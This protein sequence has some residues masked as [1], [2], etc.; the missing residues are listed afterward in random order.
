M[1]RLRARLE[2][3][4][5]SETAPKL[6]WVDN[7]TAVHI[8][9][10]DRRAIVDPRDFG[11]VSD[12]E[13]IPRRALILET[14]SI[15]SCLVL[16]EGERVLA[17][18]PLLGGIPLSKS[19]PLEVVNLLK[20]QPPIDEI[21]VGSG[22]GSSTGI[23]VGCAL[24]RTLAFG[25]RIPYKEFSSL[26]G[27][28]APNGRPFALLIHAHRAGVYLYLSNKPLSLQPVSLAELPFLLDGISTLLSPHPETI[29]LP[30]HHIER[31]S[32][33][34]QALVQ[35]LHANIFLDA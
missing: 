28:A 24:A 15:A 14:S 25:W 9:N 12:A 8:S 23:R 2:I 13:V 31:A 27:Y 6:P 21:A 3:T 7:R 11:T 16:S 33:H 32:P 26:R 17:H 34:P 30:S 29:L 1:R 5:Q 20:G 35:C 19:L 10:I 18:K 4:S 22:P